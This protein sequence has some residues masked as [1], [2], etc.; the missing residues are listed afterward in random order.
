MAER[1]LFMANRPSSLRILRFA[2]LQRA[3]VPGETGRL[4]FEASWD[5]GRRKWSSGRSWS[6]PRVRR[7][8]L[9]LDG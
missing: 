8:G 1:G 9:E 6:G 5:G 3:G 4:V 7:D 2:G